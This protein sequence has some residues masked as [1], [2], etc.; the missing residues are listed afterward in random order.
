MNKKIIGLTVTLGTGIFLIGQQ[1]VNAADNTNTTANV[2]VLGGGLTI[3]P[4]A[5]INFGTVT[6]DGQDH[7]QPDQSKS[8]LII[9]DNRG[10]TNT[11]WYLT[12]NLED[13]GKGVTGLDGMTLHLDTK[14]PDG[15]SEKGTFT[16]VDLTTDAS[17]IIS[18][19]KSDIRLSDT[20]TTA[21]LNA[22]LNI[23]KSIAA[24]TYSGTIVWNAIDGAPA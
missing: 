7:T 13:K 23:P 8:Q 20:V 16:G 24:N 11:G 15:S 9:N 6:K 18:L 5:Q 2:S 21:N 22:T 3:T 10:T 14:K 1:T 17:T 4:L 19:D 12:A